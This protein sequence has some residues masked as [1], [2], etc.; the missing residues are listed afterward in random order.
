M[1]R[2]ISYF[3]LIGASIGFAQTPPTADPTRLGPLEVNGAEYRMN[4]IHVRG[5]PW[6]TDVWGTVFFPKDLSRGPYPLVI[7]LHGNSAICRIPNTRTTAGS[8]IPPAC[9]QGT[10][11]IPNY[12]GYDYIAGYLASRP[13]SRA[14][15]S[16]STGLNPARC[17]IFTATFCSVPHSSVLTAS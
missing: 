8:L 9:P 1:N 2:L 14:S 13:S 11:Q 10:V 15:L 16:I 12:A 6:A 17:Q 4:S 5:I 3:F 7:L